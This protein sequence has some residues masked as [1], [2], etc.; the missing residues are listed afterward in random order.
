MPA[1]S[2]MHPVNT[3]ELNIG[4]SKDPNSGSKI[5]SQLANQYNTLT[6]LSSWYWL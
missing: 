1:L 2:K 6:C 5:K 4:V 3:D